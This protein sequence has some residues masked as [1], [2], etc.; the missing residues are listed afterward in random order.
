[1]F[2]LQLDVDHVIKDEPNPFDWVG[3]GSGYIQFPSVEMDWLLERFP[4][5]LYVSLQPL[6]SGSFYAITLS[7]VDGWIPLEELLAIL[8][9]ATGTGSDKWNPV[10]ND[11]SAVS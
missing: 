9:P 10:P 7:H 11:G 6:V 1:M 5:Q 4:G 2:L 3:F 8:E